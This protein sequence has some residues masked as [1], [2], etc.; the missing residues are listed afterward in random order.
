MRAQ[1]LLILG[2]VGQP[3]YN[4]IYETCLYI[5]AIATI[6]ATVKSPRLN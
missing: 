3:V 5:L 2:P 6:G 1:A 4:I